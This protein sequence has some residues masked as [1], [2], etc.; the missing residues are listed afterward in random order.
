MVFES[1]DRQSMIIYRDLMFRQIPLKMEVNT[2]IRA[3]CLSCISQLKC[4]H[5]SS[6]CIQLIFVIMSKVINILEEQI[7]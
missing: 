4:I 2:R 6:I 5:F 3:T 7:D 1:Q